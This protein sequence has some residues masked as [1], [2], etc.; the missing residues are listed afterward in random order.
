[1]VESVNQPIEVG[2]ALVR[3]GDV[4]VADGDGVVVVPREHAASVAQAARAV[5]DADK[6][7]RRGLYEG[8]GRPLDHTVSEGQ[9]AADP[10]RAP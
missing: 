3:A 5:L 6:A 8:L 4:V 10:C 2:G 9:A 7:G 1:M